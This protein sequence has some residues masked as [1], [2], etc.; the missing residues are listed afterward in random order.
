M[1]LIDDLTDR[2]LD[3]QR[4]MVTDW[5][6]FQTKV[7]P[8][9]E[10][11]IVGRVGYTDVSGPESVRY[12]DCEQWPYSTHELIPLYL[13]RCL[14]AA[15]RRTLSYTRNELAALDLRAPMHFIR[16]VEGTLA[17]VDLRRAYHTIYSRIGVL[18]APVVVTPDDVRLLPGW[19]DL[20]EPEVWAPHAL[21]R[22]ALVG[23]TRSRRRTEMR[24]G[25]VVRLSGI[26]RLTSPR[27]WRLIAL[28]LSG[29]AADMIEGYGAV[30]VHTD[31]YVV[32]ADR[33]EAAVSH[34]RDVW[35]L[36]ARVKAHGQGSVTGLGA[37][38][39]GGEGTVPHGQGRRVQRIEPTT[40]GQRAGL[41][42]ILGTAIDT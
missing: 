35:H 11:A 42:R 16:P 34:I 4:V 3:R 38:H 23:I 25:E 24:Y 19:V 6:M 28:V 8:K 31:G 18:D 1:T 29:V 27:L 21:A 5:P 20:I 37:W 7:L 13:R 40:P 39:I 10:R 30:Y 9:I 17:Y 32:P 26:S 2:L 36:D 14:E 12:V 41:R 22:N 33:A 15:G